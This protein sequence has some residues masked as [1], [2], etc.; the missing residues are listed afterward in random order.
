[1][2][3]LILYEIR[4]KKRHPLLKKGKC[5]VLKHR[6]ILK[7][8]LRDGDG[9]EPRRIS[10]WMPHEWM[11]HMLA[12]QLIDILAE[13]NMNKTTLTNIVNLDCSKHFKRVNVTHLC[14]YCCTRDHIGYMNS[15]FLSIYST[16]HKNMHWTRVHVFQLSLPIPL[17]TVSNPQ[18]QTFLLIKLIK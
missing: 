5:S 4:P 6:Y 10:R 8:H 18:Q 16:Q 9:L 15:L 7:L 1:M 2:D 3:R 12:Y 11:P 13:S 17:E 14:V